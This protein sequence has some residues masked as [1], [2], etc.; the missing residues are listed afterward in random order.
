[1]SVSEF[2]NT[3][4]TDEFAS[5]STIVVIKSS[6]NKLFF[7]NW[8]C[9]LVD[10]YSKFEY[11]WS[12]KVIYWPV[13]IVNLRL[14]SFLL[15]GIFLEENNSFVVWGLLFEKV[16]AFGSARSMKCYVMSCF[17]TITS[18]LVYVSLSLVSF[19]HIVSLSF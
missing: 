8:F 3:E 18:K 5:D 11:R 6:T 19:I 13:S 14:V 16:N 17:G 12:T 15:I 2:V 9:S 7:R 4:L 1:M 10:D